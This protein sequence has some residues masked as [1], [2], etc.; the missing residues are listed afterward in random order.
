MFLVFACAQYKF[1]CYMSQFATEWSFF[2][3]QPVLVAIFATIATVKVESIPVFY[4]LAI[5]PIN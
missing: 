4:T 3:F 1:L 2:Y 5:V